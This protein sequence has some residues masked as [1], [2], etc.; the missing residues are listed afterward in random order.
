MT[1]W[2]DY[3][4][5]DNID[6]E[7]DEER[8]YSEWLAKLEAMTPED[9]AKEWVHHCNRHD[10][11]IDRCEEINSPTIEDAAS[12][13]ET[14]ERIF[15][16]R[17]LKYLDYTQAEYDRQEA[18]IGLGDYRPVEHI[19]VIDPSALSLKQQRQQQALD[20]LEDRIT[21]LEELDI[22]TA[23]QGQAAFDEYLRTIRFLRRVRSATRYNLDMS[24]GVDPAMS[25]GMPFNDPRWAMIHNMR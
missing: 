11:A 4:Y 14:I 9:L 13:M 8:R 2:D 19:T 3:D 24:M 25:G 18:E 16:D 12:R 5:A 23:K 17:G 21:F 22:T 6:D 20:H 10:S 15:K 1:D 7:A